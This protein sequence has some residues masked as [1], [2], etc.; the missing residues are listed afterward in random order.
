MTVQW[1]P[2]KALRAHSLQR[3]RELG[4][5]IGERA[6]S[7]LDSQQNCGFGIQRVRITIGVLRGVF[8]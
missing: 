4:R 3:I 8:G 6:T 2:D 7:S 5:S 1:A